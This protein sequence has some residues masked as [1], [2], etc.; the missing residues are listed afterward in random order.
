MSRAP[1][2]GTEHVESA[3]RA[4]APMVVALVVLQAIGV[5]LAAGP[6][7]FLAV[8]GAV[9]TGLVIACTLIPR[10][11]DDRDP[12]AMETILHRV[13]LW[14][15]RGHD[16]VG[17][18]GRRDRLR[19]WLFR[20]VVV[21]AALLIV[22]IVIGV[23]TWEAGPLRVA[24]AAPGSALLVLGWLGLH[25]RD[26]LDPGFRSPVHLAATRVRSGVHLRAA[27]PSRLGRACSRLAT[28]RP[29]RR[30]LCRTPSEEDGVCL[31]CVDELARRDLGTV[32]IDGVEV[33]SHDR[34]VVAATV[35][36]S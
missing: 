1:S 30:T 23:I 20:S 6:S 13:G 15:N 19:N 26:L 3:S 25:R 5:G 17:A 34:F 29:S 27:H 18:V 4:N 24:L 22:Q 16:A 8:G 35:S 36:D 33:D 11:A 14:P 10:A 31:D 7:G 9:L 2:S 32:R 21:G 28:I 12:D